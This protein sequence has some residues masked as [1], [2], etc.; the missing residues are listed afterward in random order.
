VILK[1]D[2]PELLIFNAKW[3]QLLIV[4]FLTYLKNRLFNIRNIIILGVL[5]LAD[6]TLETVSSFCDLTFIML[7]R[8]EIY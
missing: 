7:F 4:A 2:P 5:N 6:I 1:F 8:G 3:V